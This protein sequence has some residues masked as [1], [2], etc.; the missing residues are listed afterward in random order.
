MSDSKKKNSKLRIQKLGL[1][2]LMHVNS[3]EQQWSADYRLENLPRAHQ[4]ILDSLLE[5]GA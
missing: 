2:S 4:R 3:Q 5:N 1:C